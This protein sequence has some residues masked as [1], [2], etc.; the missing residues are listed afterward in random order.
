[1]LVDATLN[2]ELD[3]SEL[4]AASEAVKRSYRAAITAIR[5]DLETERPS[6]FVV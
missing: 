1:M 4:L 3:E 6:R 2:D 5:P